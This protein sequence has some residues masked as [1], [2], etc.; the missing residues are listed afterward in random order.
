MFLRGRSDQRSVGEAGPSSRS[1]RVV[2]KGGGFLAAGDLFNYGSRLVT[3]LVLARVLKAD[4]Y[5][6]YTLSV[7]IAFLAAGLANLGLDSAMER[8][9]AILRARGDQQGVRGTLQLGIG[10]TCL[11]ILTVSAVGFFGADA[12]ATQVFDDPR[13]APLLQIMAFAMPFVVTT[14][15]FAAIVRGFKRM[16][17]SALTDD[18]IQPLTRLAL[19]GVFA[20]I[21][22][23]VEVAIIIFGISYLLATAVLVGLVH[24]LFPLDRNVREAQHYIK[25]IGTFSFPFWFAGLLTQIRQNIQPTL[26][27]VYSTM[28][29]VGIF[30]LV[31][32]ANLLGRVANMSV[33]TSLRP[34]LAEALD[35]GDHEQAEHLYQA[36]TRWTLTAN[37]PVFLVMILY[38]AAIL[39]LFGESF[40]AGAAALFV[41]AF[42]E[43]S[44][45]AT[46]TCGTVIDMSGLNLVKL[47]NKIFEVVF[48]LALNVVLIVNYGLMGAAVATLVSTATIQIIRLVEVRIIVGLHP[49]NLRILKPVAAGVAALLAGLGIDRVVPADGGILALAFDALIVGAVYVGALVMLG[50]TDEDRE[51]MQ[52]VAKRLRLPVRR[53]RSRAGRRGGP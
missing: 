34:T 40:E 20:A 5:G 15:L 29:N 32:S 26:L 44:N 52:A 48:T 8:Y 43:L 39:S 6:L 2:A 19:I 41:L 51:I 27:G 45:A 3:A 22:L 17:Y 46:G 30:S 4:E 33:R 13:L 24:R 38:P 37:L 11:G 31:T 9:I 42:S 49:Y 18:F 16:D 23:T 1:L 28:A 35:R 14:T 7:S 47:I 21:G 25:E 53:T 36:T 50:L 10:L 12:L